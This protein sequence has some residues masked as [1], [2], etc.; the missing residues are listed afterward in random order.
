M[1]L[2]TWPFWQSDCASRLETTF[3]LRSRTLSQLDS[4]RLVLCFI[5]SVISAC[6]TTTRARPGQPF[7][8]E[9][10]P[11][12]SGVMRNLFDDEFGGF[13]LGMAWENSVASQSALTEKRALSARQ[14][15][16]C[17]V[18]TVTEGSNGQNLAAIVELK[19]PGKSLIGAAEVECP[20]LQVPGTSFSYSILRQTG[21]SL[22]GKSVVIFVRDFNDGGETSWHWH[23]EPDRP[24]IRATVR[25]LRGQ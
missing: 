13:A 12:Y 8:S 2:L 14:I 18:G 15:A 23:V 16:L 11:S 3:S 10:L 21:G 20:K 17:S 25:Q 9:P 24:D 6:Q 22:V 1:R 4:L 5:G 19:S 7:D